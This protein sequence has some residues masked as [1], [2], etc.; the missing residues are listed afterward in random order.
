MPYGFNFDLSKLP[1]R[2]FQ[3]ILKQAAKVIDE[4]NG[5]KKIEGAVADLM[6]K[7][8]VDELTGLNT[9][10]TLTILRH[11]V[12][13]NVKN[14]LDR[15]RFFETKINERVVFLPHCSRKYMDRRCNAYFDKKIPSYVCNACSDDCLINQAT[16]LARK[17]GYD[18]HILSGGS[19]IPHILEKKRKYK[20]VFGVACTFELDFGAKYL[21]DK[22]IPGQGLP[23]INNG[24][25]G[26]EF[27]LESYEKILSRDS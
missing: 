22:N 5:S 18:V 2:F 10:N 24:C 15:N 14:L 4:T 13:I 11:L 6:K 23:L 8:R 25:A 27:N 1:Q 16:K 21:K 20:A 19:C 9:G 3:D 26:T 7:F 17:Y 12:D